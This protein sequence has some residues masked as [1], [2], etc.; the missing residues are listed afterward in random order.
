MIQ[1][2]G[3]I[4]GV[5]NPM[6]Q[7]HE[8][9]WDLLCVLDLPNSTGHIYSAEEKKWE[10]GSGLS[11][12]NQKAGAGSS[13]SSS[14]SSTVANTNAAYEDAPH[15]STDNRFRTHCFFYSYSS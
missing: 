14:A 3:Y 15:Y 10:D 7:Q 9:W 8:S 11:F 2:P 1:V 6:F 12:A 13:S 4:A 5:T